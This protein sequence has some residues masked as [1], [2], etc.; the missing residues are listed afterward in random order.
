[1][2]APAFDHLTKQHNYYIKFDYNHTTPEFWS[3]R[4]T[5]DNR[6]PYNRQF[7][8]ARRTD[9]TRSCHQALECVQTPNELSSSSRVMSYTDR[10]P[11]TCWRRL[12]CWRRHACWRHHV[13]SD[14]APRLLTYDTRLTASRLL[15]PRRCVRATTS[16]TICIAWQSITRLP[17]S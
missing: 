2:Y 7:L 3:N 16:W 11:H 12:A 1:M 8:I 9:R 6:S 14:G 13:A 10:L 17:L 15:T 5:H 4:D